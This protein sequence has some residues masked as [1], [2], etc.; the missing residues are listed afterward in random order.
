MR[1]QLLSNGQGIFVDRGIVPS[2]DGI[3]YLEV[4]NE[5]DG[6]KLYVNGISAT[7]GEC[8]Y[9]AILKK[10]ENTVSYRKGTIQYRIEKLLY[11]GK[12]I[13]IDSIVGTE[14]QYVSIATEM[15]S[16]KAKLHEALKQIEELKKAINGTQLFQ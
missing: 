9:T 7:K 5:Q 14:E 6:G 4:A 12:N 10:G 15:A 1:I 3:A 8:E 11:D 16:V 2:K 13:V